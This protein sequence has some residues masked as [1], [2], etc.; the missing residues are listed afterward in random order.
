MHK[1]LLFTNPGGSLLRG[2]KII[3]EEDFDFSG[4]IQSSISASEQ[5][6]L[7]QVSRG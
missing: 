2:K 6:T 3:Q 1:L 5:R 7:A 4:G